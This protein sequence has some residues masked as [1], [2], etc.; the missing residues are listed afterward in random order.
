MV[1]PEAIFG[2]RTFTMKV[3]ECRSIRRRLPPHASLGGNIV[4]KRAG[5]HLL[6]AKDAAEEPNVRIAIC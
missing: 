6:E 4:V 3:T 5:R 1:G 2:W